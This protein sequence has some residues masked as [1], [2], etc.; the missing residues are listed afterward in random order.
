MIKIASDCGAD[1]VKFQTHLAEEETIKDAPMPS[2]FKGEPRFD[3]FKRT[4]F[5]VEQWKELK[6]SCDNLNVEFMS[7]PFS[8]KA[9]ELLEK[10]GVNRY[11][12]PSGEVTNIPL[13]RVIAKTNKPIIIS[14]GMSD[15]NELDEALNTILKHNDNVTVLQCTSEYP[16]KYKNIGINVMIEMRDRYNL[17]IGLSDHSL[18]NYS[19]FS[20]V[21]LGASVI[22]K[23]LTFNRT[24][25]G[26]DAKHSLEPSEFSDLVEGIRAIE[27]M[28]NNKIDK[29]DMARKMAHM[30]EVFQKSIVSIV[31]IPKGTKIRKEMIGFKKPGSG[32]S[33]SKLNELIGRITN[34]NILK[35]NLIQMNDL[36]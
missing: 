9:V 24:M 5:N 22:E 16:C 13:L 29:D 1:I 3:Y 19:S 36:L 30:K 28:L 8:I 10:I 35:D 27:E 14:S 6:T 33:P 2:F 25:Y 26:S 18:T 32:I 34:K 21:T 15:W 4:G 23:H 12:I 20:A 11:K 31:D 17:P 7:S